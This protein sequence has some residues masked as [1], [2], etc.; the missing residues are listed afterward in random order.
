MGGSKQG[1]YALEQSDSREYP[2]IRAS[3]YGKWDQI[4]ITIYFSLALQE[5]HNLP[6]PS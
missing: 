1:D 3:S 5:S 4:V 6:N 2:N